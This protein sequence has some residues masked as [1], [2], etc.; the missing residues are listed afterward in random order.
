MTADGLSRQRPALELQDV[1]EGDRLGITL[2]PLPGIPSNDYSFTFTS[3]CIILS[4]Y[5]KEQCR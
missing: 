3:G 2:H 1:V 5:N 4:H